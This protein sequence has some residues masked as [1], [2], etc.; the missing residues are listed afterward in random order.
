MKW[1]SV[2]LLEQRARAAGLANVTAA[3]GRIEEFGGP[4]DVALALHACGRWVAR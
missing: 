2:E 3:V 4:C 1:R